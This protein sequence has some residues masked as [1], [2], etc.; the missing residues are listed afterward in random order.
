MKMKTL[1]KLP[2]FILWYLSGSIF[3]ALIAPLLYLLLYSAII[4][5]IPIVVLLLLPNSIGMKGYRSQPY[6]GLEDV[7]ELIVVSIGM[8]AV[9]AFLRSAAII[10]YQYYPE[11]LMMID[12]PLIITLDFFGFKSLAV[13]DY[14]IGVFGILVFII[15]ACEDTFWR[16]A[17]H[18]NIH[19]MP[20]SKAR[21]IA[22]G[23]VKIKGVV[24]PLEKYRDKISLL[25]HC[26]SNESDKSNYEFRLPFFLEDET[27]KIM[28]D[29]EG[30][31]FATDTG[32]HGEQAGFG[33]YSSLLPHDYIGTILLPKHQKK[34]GVGSTTYSMQQGDPVYVLGI[35]QRREPDR[36]SN[37]DVIIRP[38]K[39]LFG[40]KHHDVFF[41]TNG[42]YQQPEKYFYHGLWHAW[43]LTL[44]CTA[45]IGWMIMNAQSGMDN[46]EAAYGYKPQ[47]VLDKFYQGK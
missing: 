34:R 43:I 47:A 40:H 9:V 21:S 28:I 26:K 15:I 1:L 39:G 13:Y 41:L 12:A 6:N 11:A 42:M 17:Q 8:L 25:Q 38:N 2:L 32:V 14:Y 31:N 46:Y 22:M 10:L 45:C 37:A 24:K 5:F 35:A 33:Q 30:A 19:T 27:G 36:D 4:F 16:I 18:R 3:V 44:V 20:F 29:T 23:M 7:K